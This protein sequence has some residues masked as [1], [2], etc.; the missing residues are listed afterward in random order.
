MQLPSGESRAIA[1]GLTAKLG[2]LE[3]VCDPPD[4]ELYVN[5]SA[6][7]SANQSLELTAVPHQIE[8]KKNG[9]ES[10]TTSV[11]PRPGF[12]QSASSPVI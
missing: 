9:F 6:R 10:Y 2:L 11:T 1:I 12:S 7:G 5:G 3:I 4:A 8:I